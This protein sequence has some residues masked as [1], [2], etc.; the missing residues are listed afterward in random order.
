MDNLDVKKFLRMNNILFNL[1]LY[2]KFYSVPKMQLQ[3]ICGRVVTERV[4]TEEGKIIN[5]SIV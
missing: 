5:V 4:K 2:F 1:F 3:V